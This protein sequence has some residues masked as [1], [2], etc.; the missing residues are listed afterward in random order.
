M[1]F[2]LTGHSYYKYFN[3]VFNI[4]LRAESVIV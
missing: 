2:I 1:N 3:L 4:V